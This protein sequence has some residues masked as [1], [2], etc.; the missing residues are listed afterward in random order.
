MVKTVKGKLL[1]YHSWYITE[2]IFSWDALIS[3]LVDFINFLL[4]TVEQL[5]YEY[6]I[7]FL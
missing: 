4:E 7:V 2:K 6:D 5:I 1:T 3:C